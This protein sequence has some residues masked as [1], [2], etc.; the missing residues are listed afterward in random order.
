MSLSEDVSQLQ[1]AAL[2][3]VDYSSQRHQAMDIRVADSRKLQAAWS[4]ERHKT[5]ADGQV[6][7]H[8]RGGTE[9]S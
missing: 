9:R 5:S 8:L 4:T 2:L 7:R 3:Q 6:Q 1:I